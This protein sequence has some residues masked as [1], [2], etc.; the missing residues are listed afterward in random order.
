MSM[1]DAKI[2]AAEAGNARQREKAEAEVKIAD[3]VLE[4]TLRKALQM[5]PFSVITKEELKKLRRLQV[6]GG[7]KTLRGL[8][9]AENLS[10]ILL[11]NS[12]IDDL[13][14]LYER[15]VN[16]A[17][18]KEGNPLSLLKV[19]L[20]NH[21]AREAAFLGKI[22]DESG[23][24]VYLSGQGPTVEKA[25]DIYCTYE[26][27]T[28]EK[29]YGDCVI[30]GECTLPWLFFEDGTITYTSKNKRLV[31]VWGPYFGESVEVKIGNCAGR[32]VIEARAG[33]CV[34][35]IFVTVK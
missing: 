19:R 3:P 2:T 1:N 35:K 15:K 11:D 17:A 30:Y 26:S 34:K 9:Y 6:D 27:M 32:A 12:M 18:G 21:Q 31:K 20:N 29:G 23:V 24:Q 33:C 25:F 28:V 8:E 7:V 13:S 16:D 5:E 14:P 22:P 4:V 10:E